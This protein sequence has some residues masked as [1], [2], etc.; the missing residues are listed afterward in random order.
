[1]AV[2]TK[3]AQPADGCA[4]MGYPRMKGGLFRFQVGLFAHNVEGVVLVV[5]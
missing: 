2:G 1:M 4:P 5:V 3:K